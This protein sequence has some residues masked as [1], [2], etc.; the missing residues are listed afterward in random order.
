[1]IKMAV[2][3]SKFDFYIIKDSRNL[4]CNS[5]IMGI[6]EAGRGPVLGPL[7]I[8][9]FV[10]CA[11][12]VL[13]FLEMGLKDSKELTP[14]QRERIYLQLLRLPAI[15]LVAEI[16]PRTIDNWIESGKSLNELEAYIASYL[17]KEAYSRCKKIRYV[18]IDAPSTS[19]SYERYLHKYLVLNKIAL[20]VEEKADKT[21]LIVSAAS[22]IAKYIR[23]ARIREISKRLGINVGSGYPSDPHTRRVLSLL[24][25]RYPEFVRKSWKTIK[26]L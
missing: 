6:D 24:L 9:G 1:M 13:R 5:I 7:V 25:E 12:N 2:P 19:E 23:D 8:C 10:T 22:V 4:S 17:I 20:F 21:R 16:W 3:E 26:K 11:L 15:I 14:H 18:F